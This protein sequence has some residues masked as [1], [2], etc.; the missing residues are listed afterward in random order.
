MHKPRRPNHEHRPAS[1]V[2]DG[3][4]PEVRGA[5]RDWRAHMAHGSE[6]AEPLDPATDHVRGDIGAPVV[7]VEYGCLGSRGESSEDRAL[8]ERLRGLL[9]GGRI[10]LAF[11]HF[12]LIDSHPGAWLAAQAVEAADR[13]GRFW[14]MHDALTDAFTLP[15]A[16]ELDHD[17]I[18]ALARRLKLDLDRLEADMGH[19]STAARVLK[20]LYGAIRSGANGA[21]TF[22]VQ[23]VRQDIGGP[24]ELVERIEAAV[25][26]DFAALW[27]P[28]HTHPKDTTTIARMWHEGLARGDVSAAAECWHDDIAWRGWNDELPGGGCA[29]GRK[30]VEALHQRAGA[31]HI[32]LRVEPR[33]YIEHDNR[34]LVIGDAHRDASAGAFHVPYV[35]IWEID[36]GK[37]TRVDTVTDT[38]AIAH[39]IAGLAPRD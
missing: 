11:R 30:A 6:L 10:C 17:A 37:A 18:R 16:R 34:V 8:R 33:E 25:A 29:T 4:P 2:G 23:G 3:L 1:S 15:W 31:A 7:V 13:Q 19:H 38:R 21:P 26:G 22:Y 9:D 35:Q 39:A 27:P 5:L 12:P 14:D 28:V 32:D 24:D 20:D 36:A